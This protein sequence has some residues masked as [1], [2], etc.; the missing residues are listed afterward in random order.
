MQTSKAT[1]ILAGGAVLIGG[2]VVG[3]V[4]VDATLN[5]QKWED[6]TE[7]SAPARSIDDSLR[8]VAT[9]LGLVLML[10]QLPAL[11]EQSK[12]IGEELEAELPS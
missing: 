4:A 5:N 9:S 6:K 1:A 8:F 7:R 11:V 12:K 2:I 10:V 3:K